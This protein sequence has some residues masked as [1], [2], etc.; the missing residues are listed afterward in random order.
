MIMRAKLTTAAALACLIWAAPA[1]Q[2]ADEIVVTDRDAFGGEGGVFR[3]DP[4]TGTRSVLSHNM[5]P[6]GGPSFMEPT[7]ISLDSSGHLLVTDPA[8][9]DDLGGGVIVLDPVT[10]QRTTLSANGQPVGVP[11]FVEPEGLTIDTGGDLLVADQDAFGGGGGV[12][13][14]DRQ[15][16]ERSVVS[17]N[18]HPFGGPQFS[19]PSSVRLDE[20]G[21]LIV[22]DWA[23][24]GGAGQILRVDIAT[25]ARTVISAND[26]P[27][28]SPEFV[29]PVG[30]GLGADGRLI[31]S[32]FSA[33]ADHSGGILRVDP[34]TGARTTL[35]SNAEQ[36][37][38]DLVDPIG[39]WPDANGDLIVADPA[40]F[41]LP[42]SGGSIIR[43]DGDTGAR[44]SVSNNTE[45]PGPL[46]VHPIVPIVAP[47]AT[48]PPPPP[49]PTPPPPPPPPS[50]PSDGDDLI[51]GTAGDDRICG[52]G[53]D[54]VIM[55]LAGDDTLFG[56]R[57]GAAAA[58]GMAA[59]TGDG[60]DSING[61]VG[62]DRLYGSGGA[63][64]L[65][66]G[67][68]NDR[69]VGGSG[70]DRLD[71]GSGR[72]R[73]RARDRARDTVI[74]GKGRDTVVADARDRLR[75]CERVRR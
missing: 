73:I 16:G 52:L 70:R 53:G 1:A 7:G 20:N 25:G 31:V 50:G 40:Y 14:V 65:R 17:S 11:N 42:G 61:G 60:D 66:G 9:F 46:F 62:N 44:T 30:A 24:F 75:G 12:I 23:G 8:A 58:D 27:A 71:G 36:D 39:F 55:G 4:A 6:A 63:D 15:T 68:G 5:H 22:A 49:P 45:H 56:D 59:A 34:V 69:L 41:G 48:P 51:I 32:D 29:D 67:P 2:A 43:V 37:G 57:C 64:R 54:D 19:D 72:D 21:D 33:F 3:V 47:A 38:P 13:R 18:Q 28:G 35:S 26:A 74:C 10:G